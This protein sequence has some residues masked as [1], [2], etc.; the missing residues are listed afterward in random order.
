[1]KVDGWAG[2]D[3]AFIVNKIDVFPASRKPRT[4]SLKNASGLN[5]KAEPARLLPTFGEQLIGPVA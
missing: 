2:W 5:D 3:E 4:W 1:M